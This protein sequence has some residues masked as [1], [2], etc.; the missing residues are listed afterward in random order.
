MADIVDA[1]ED[2]WQH[3][4]VTVG[5]VDAACIL[6]TKAGVDALRYFGVR[7]APLPVQLEVL[8]PVFAA[9]I[10]AGGDPGAL[11][12]DS[13]AW[14]VAID[15]DTPTNREG[16]NG[17]LVL[18]LPDTNELV[19]LTLDQTRRRHKQIEVNPARCALPSG[20]FD[21]EP[22]IFMMNGCR[23]GYRYRAD[24]RGTWQHSPDWRINP[25]KTTGPM[26][27]RMKAQDSSRS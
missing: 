5:F 4:K 6:A 18:H 10:E 24:L 21:G 19:D 22:L 11:T 1:L 20:F 27:R 17:H 14:V 26:I 3:V 8:N 25:K 2:A 13:G 12:V 23:V 7:A 16:W 9:H 15:P